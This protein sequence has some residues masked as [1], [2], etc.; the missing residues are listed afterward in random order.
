MQILIV[1][2][3]M[4]TIK[5]NDCFDLSIISSNQVTVGLSH[6]SALFLS[7]PMFALPT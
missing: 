7:I 1:E 5:L 6:N 4:G 3:E 2:K